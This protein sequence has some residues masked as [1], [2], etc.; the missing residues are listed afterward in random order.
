MYVHLSERLILNLVVKLHWCLL[1]N[2]RPCSDVASKSP[3]NTTATDWAEPGGQSKLKPCWVVKC[4]VE[5]RCS[6]WTTRQKRSWHHMGTCVGPTDTGELPRSRPPSFRTT[7]SMLKGERWPYFTST[8]TLQN[9][10]VL[11]ICQAQL[12]LKMVVDKS[13]W[14]E[15]P[16]KTSFLCLN[17]ELLSGKRIFSK[18]SS[19]RSG[20]SQTPLSNPGEC[21]GKGLTLLLH[22]SANLTEPNPDK[23][24]L[25]DSGNYPRTAFQSSGLCLLTWDTSPSTF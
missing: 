20:L 12:P 7:A 21:L 4:S 3:W 25:R 19:R 22:T 17:P 5:S 8:G 23:A 18:A 13:N 11:Y 16:S 14:Q 24:C 2:V 6:W 15:K 1:L 9:F 10:P